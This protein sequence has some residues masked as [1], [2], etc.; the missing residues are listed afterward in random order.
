MDTDKIHNLNNA[1]RNKQN[2]LSALKENGIKD[3]DI[4]FSTN[5]R[6]T[7]YKA[8]IKYEPIKNMILNQLIM[9][10]KKEI[11]EAKKELIK[12]IK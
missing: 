8:D 6:Y 9:Q 5:D 11:S 7:Q 2:I 10:Y 3:I 1:V 12:L 4:S